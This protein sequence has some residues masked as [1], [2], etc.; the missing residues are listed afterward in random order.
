MNGILTN[1]ELSPQLT[2]SKEL[3]FE[4]NVNGWES[5]SQE[6]VRLLGEKAKKTFMNRNCVVGEV[7]MYLTALML[8]CQ[9]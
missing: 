1:C 8:P 3:M 9:A 5:S 6:E 4:D 2:N 7:V